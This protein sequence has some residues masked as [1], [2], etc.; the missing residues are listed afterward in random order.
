MIRRG[1]RFSNIYICFNNG[2]TLAPSL[3]Y[4]QS[5]NLDVWLHNEGNGVW[6]LYAYANSWDS[7]EVVD[8]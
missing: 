8:F 2:D 4:I 1:G 5:D 6:A 7:L 3:N